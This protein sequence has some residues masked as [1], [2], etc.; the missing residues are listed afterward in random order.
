MIEDCCWEKTFEKGFSPLFQ[1][2]HKTNTALSMR[3]SPHG[4]AIF[5]YR[6]WMVLHLNF[7]CNVHLFFK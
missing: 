3:F 2:F 1:N 4:R 6:V 5:V 7:A